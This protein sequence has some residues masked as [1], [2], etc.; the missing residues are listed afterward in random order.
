M[1]EHQN[2]V[3]S[4]IE[5][6][7]EIVIDADRQVSIALVVLIAFVNPSIVNDRRRPPPRNR[8]RSPVIDRYQPDRDRGRD[9]YYD[10]NAPPRDREDRRRAP[11][12]TAAN[13]DRYVPG[14]DADKPTVRVNPLA[15]PLS[16]DT[17]AGFS[18]FAD[19]WRFEQQIKEEKERAKHGGRRPS[20]RIKGEREVREDREKERAQIQAAYDQYKQDFQCKMARQFVMQHKGEEWFKERYVKELSEPIRKRLM[21]F[22]EAAFDQWKSDMETGVFDEFTLEGI[23]KNDSDGAGGM[24]STLR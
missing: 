16:L 12:P 17:Q 6:N 4:M 21:E 14:Q 2:E 3:R 22:R 1:T 13:I 7:G 20:D 18:F 24:V 8:S 23:Y 5:G 10:R 11:S 19:W 15:N 9:D